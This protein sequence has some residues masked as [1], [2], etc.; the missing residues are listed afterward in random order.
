MLSKIN[1]SVIQFFFGSAV[2]VMHTQNDPDN[3]IDFE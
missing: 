1:D 2:T 3:V